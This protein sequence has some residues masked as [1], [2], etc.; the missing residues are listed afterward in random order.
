MTI[1][2]MT[3]MRGATLG[4]AKVRGG[5]PPLTCPGTFTNSSQFNVLTFEYL[6]AILITS[7]EGRKKQMA[8]YLVRCEKIWEDW[9][10]A[11]NEDD[12]YEQAEAIF[13][14][15]DSYDIYIEYT[16]EDDENE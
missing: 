2:A 7:D 12:A 14:D 3:P 6:Y 15:Y 11:D 10:E 8:K 1:Q 16:E 4:I 9:V 13:E 5:S